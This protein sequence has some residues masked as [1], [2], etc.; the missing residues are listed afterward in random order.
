VYGAA[1]SR[2]IKPDLGSGAGASRST[3]MRRDTDGVAIM[4]N[5]LEGFA[6]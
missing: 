6:K 5:S 3:R 1:W 2:G 4:K